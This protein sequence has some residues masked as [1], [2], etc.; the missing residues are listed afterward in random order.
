MYVKC[1]SELTSMMS[2]MMTAS[3][4][5]WL[6]VVHG[7]AVLEFSL[8]RIKEVHLGQHGKDQNE[9]HVVK[10]TPVSKFLFSHVVRVRKTVSIE[11][12]QTT[13]SKTHLNNRNNIIQC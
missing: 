10:A 6:F 5:A 1:L 7:P 4:A 13:L 12:N 9:F 8:H 11:Q 2:K 3:I